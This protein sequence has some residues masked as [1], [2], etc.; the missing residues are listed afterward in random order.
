MA[1]P[2]TIRR[3]VLVRH[4][5]PIVEPGRPAAEWRLGDEG[6]AGAQRLAPELRRFNPVAVASSV[7]PKAWETAAIVAQRLGVPC[8]AAAGLHEHARPVPEHLGDRALFEARVRALFER[9][10]ELVYGAETASQAAKRFERAA[11]RVVAKWSDP[12][13][14][15]D[16]PRRAPAGIERGL[17]VVAHGTVISL[18]AQ[19]WCGAEP[20]ELWRSLAL[21]S[22]VVISLPNRLLTR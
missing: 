21:P 1:T 17:V 5:A 14:W 12:A 16:V 2:S 8:E 3:L 18:L 7:E 19:A 13:S 9:P 22:Y 10:D 15:T 11:G 20:F 4:A 6:R